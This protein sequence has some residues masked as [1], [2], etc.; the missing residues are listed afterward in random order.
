[1]G[2]GGGILTMSPTT[3][4]NRKDHGKRCGQLS[5]SMADVLT[6]FLAMSKIFGGVTL[7]LSTS[8]SKL[9]EKLFKNL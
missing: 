1:M 6:D 5:C 2:G 9:P 7:V 4:T 8:F 3:V